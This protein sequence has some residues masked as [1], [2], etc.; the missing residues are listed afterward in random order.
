MKSPYIGSTGTGSP[1]TPLCSA[2][3][4]ES[5]SNLF[6]MVW[7]VGESCF[8]VF[9][10]VFGHKLN[11]VKMQEITIQAIPQARGR[12][13][14]LSCFFLI[15]ASFS[16]TSLILGRNSGSS[17]K[18]SLNLSSISGSKYSINLVKR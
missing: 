15:R 10:D 18:H 17:E 5:I 2:L 1:I 12:D 9:L 4:G 16:K 6:P 13:N 8:G 3:V 7:G 14:F 11:S